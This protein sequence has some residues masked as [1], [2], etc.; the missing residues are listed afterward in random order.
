MVAKTKTYG[1][2]TGRD[3]ADF[4]HFHPLLSNWF[5]QH[6]EMSRAE[7]PKSTIAGRTGRRKVMTQSPPP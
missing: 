1:K 5:T 2:K 6:V 7:S 4:C 3:L